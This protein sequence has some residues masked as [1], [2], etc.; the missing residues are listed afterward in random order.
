MTKQHVILDAA[1]DRS[2]IRGTLTAP[3]GERR[4]FHGWLEL[5][6]ALEAML[7]AG[8]ERAYSSLAGRVAVTDRSEVS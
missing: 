4:E 1:I 6:V 3:S 7:G 2:V 5:S 8:R